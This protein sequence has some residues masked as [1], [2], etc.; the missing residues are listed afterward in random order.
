MALG[1][2]L[3]WFAAVLPTFTLLGLLAGGSVTAQELA[4]EN[5]PSAH[6][7]AQPRLRTTRPSDYSDGL[8]ASF[9]RYRPWPERR[10]VV[11]FFAR[12]PLRNYIAVD[13]SPSEDSSSPILHEYLHSFTHENYPGVPVWFDEGLAEYY[14]TFAIVGA[15]ARVGLLVVPHLDWLRAGNWL[16]L[17]ELLRV[18]HTSAL[19]H[20]TERTGTF[21]AQ[22]WLLVHYLMSDPERSRQLGR[23]LD[24]LAAAEPLEE[25]LATA[26]G[27]GAVPALERVLRRYLDSSRFTFL[28]V[29]HDPQSFSVA[30]GPL[31]LPRALAQLGELL[32]AF[33]PP[34]T[35][36]ALRH[37]AA[38]LEGAPQE[39]LAL[40]GLGRLRALAGDEEGAIDHYRRSAAS[41]LALPQL[42]LGAALLEPLLA[43]ASFAAL[44]PAE[45]ARLAEARTALEAASA[46][47]A[48]GMAPVLLA[49][50][51]LFDGDAAQGLALFAAA[52]RRMPSRSEVYYGQALLVA[53]EPDAERA[54]AICDRLAR[55][56]AS[57]PRATAQPAYAQ[58]ARRTVVHTLLYAAGQGIERGDEQKTLA[59][60]SDLEPRLRELGLAGFDQTLHGLRSVA[61]HNLAVRA[62]RELTALAN[63]GRLAEALTALDELL[64][65]I[66]D[67]GMRGQAEEFRR[68]L[69][70]ALGARRP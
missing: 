54:F 32:L 65:R 58:A 33:D 26:F 24:G 63:A 45:Q 10:N 19:Y 25:A 66:E 48:W 59:V 23:L 7:P 42:A 21:Y 4:P 30:H 62:L 41:G 46:E 68:Q 2:Q 27:A 31:A 44:A 12:G 55:L 13:L 3:G 57:R 28:K 47:G 20:E 50:T 5:S 11:G 64:P 37:F 16:P 40:L 1:P 49:T 56:E 39:P 69:V 6:S 18:D 29:P 38:A 51:Y 43:R 61:H 70:N 15:E 60:L 67:E 9:A 36:E 52:Q 22:S 17:D 14:S 35:G 34:P 8:L 53:R